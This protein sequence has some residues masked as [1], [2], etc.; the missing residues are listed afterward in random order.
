MLT[1]AGAA[2]A[3]FNFSLQPHQIGQDESLNVMVPGPSGNIYKKPHSSDENYMKYWFGIGPLHGKIKRVWQLRPIQILGF[4]Q[5]SSGFCPAFRRN[6][7][8]W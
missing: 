7:F 4:W 6:V 2:S 5:G 3:R 1:Q 8:L